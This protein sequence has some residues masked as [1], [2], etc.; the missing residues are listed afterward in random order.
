MEHYVADWPAGF[1]P[2]HPADGQKVELNGFIGEST[3]KN[4]CSIKKGFASPIGEPYR[5]LNSGQK[6][7]GIHNRLAAE[8]DLFKLIEGACYAYAQTKDPELLDLITENLDHILKHQDSDGFIRYP[9]RENLDKKYYHD[10]YIAGHYIEMSAAHHAATG[11]T[12][13]L[14]SACKWADA[15]IKAMRD[16][17]DYFKDAGKK[18]HPELELALVR[19]FRATGEQKYLD[20]AEKIIDSYTLSN[21]I[22]DLWIGSGRT[23]VVRT[24]YLLMGCAE[25]YLTTGNNRYLNYVQS[26]WKEICETRRYITGGFGYNE[27]FPLYPWFL[28]ETG[29]IAETCGSIAMMMLGL[30]VHSINGYCDSRVYDVIENIFYNHFLGALNAEQDAIFYYNPIRVLPSVPEMLTLDNGKPVNSR[31]KLPAIHSCS[32]CFPNTWRFLAQLP[33]YIFSTDGSAV[34]VNM[35]TDATAIIDLKDGPVEIK[36][37]TGYPFD[38]TIEIEASRD[39]MLKLRIPG[40]CEGAYVESSN[41]VEQAPSGSY[42]DVR[43]GGAKVRLVLPMIPRFVGASPLSAEGTGR[44]AA[45]RGPLVYCYEVSN[46][47]ERA[48]LYRIPLPQTPKL[49]PGTAHNLE[50]SAV[51]MNNGEGAYFTV[52]QKPAEECRITLTPFYQRGNHSSNEPGWITMFPA[53]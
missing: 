32:C 26:L 31:T 15:L 35:Y 10:L 51:K 39:I 30:R 49:V 33:D 37:K 34:A 36:V 22:S 16:E 21:K 29:R 20:F 4:I 50:V 2:I 1:A 38:E 48:E 46:T 42:K 13:A 23:H 52:C 5:L 25:F 40:W 28:P 9:N 6:L 7:S 24:A 3:A 8:S 18:E 27:W 53:I 11:D 43:T 44:V 19:L 12:R 14:S 47:E 45:A 17:A 41:G